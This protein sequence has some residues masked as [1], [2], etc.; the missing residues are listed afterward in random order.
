MA[1]SKWKRKPKVSQKEHVEKLVKQLDEGVES[2]QYDPEEFKIYLRMK[3]LMPN[4]SFRNLLVAK[5]QLSHASYIA[6]MSK[7]NNLDRR[8]TKGETAIRIFKPYFK[9]VKNEEGEEEMKFI[10]WITVP[11]FDVSQTHGAPLP[12]DELK[13]ELE[14]DCPEARE[15]LKLVET[16]ADCPIYYEKIKSGAKGFYRP[17]EHSITISN[18]LSTN[19]QAKTAVH[20]Y[21]HS[22]CH[23][24][25]DKS[26]RKEQEVVAEGCAFVVCSYFG[27]DTSDYSFRYVK[28][29]AD[30]DDDA[31]MKYGSQICDESQKII[32]KFEAHMPKESRRIH[33]ESDEKEDAA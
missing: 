23:G 13:I 33:V 24:L 26:S 14:G 7:W 28:G 10:R 32:K 19:H 11:V 29:W 6:P 25:G 12:I 1:K 3:A 9:K 21:V 5:A 16:I 31:L 8:V 27:L 4:Y 20:E 18:E 30:G 22:V 15:I 2:F 17:S